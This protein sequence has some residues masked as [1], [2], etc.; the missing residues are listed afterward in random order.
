MK[1]GSMKRS[2][3]LS[4]CLVAA[5]LVTLGANNSCK[6]PLN[7]AGEYSGTWT[8][9]YKEGGTIIDTKDCDCTMTLVQDVTSPWPL[10]LTL[11]GTLNVNLSCLDEWENWPSGLEYPPFESVEGLYGGTVANSD[12]SISVDLGSEVSWLEVDGFLDLG[13]F[14]ESNQ[15]NVDIPEMIRY[16]GEWELAVSGVVFLGN[17]TINGTFDV[18]RV[19]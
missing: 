1:G 13:G 7:T 19:E 6:A 11:T 2:M 17:V 5:S 12:G 8:F 18:T 9:N 15:S 3:F 16:S 14:G 4:L 10:N